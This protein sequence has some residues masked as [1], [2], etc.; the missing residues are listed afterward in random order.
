N[1][2]VTNLPAVGTL[3]NVRA[4]AGTAGVTENNLRGEARYLE[5]FNRADVAAMPALQAVLQDVTVKG[6][7]INHFKTNA[8]PDAA[9]LR[10]RLA[11]ANTAD[12][13]RAV[14]HDGG[15]FGNAG[16][17][18]NTATTLNDANQAARI[19]Q[20]R[21]EARYQKL[22]AENNA[23]L[24]TMQ[25]VKDHLSAPAVKQALI[26]HW[27]N[28]GN[29]A[30]DYA[31][32]IINLREHLRQL[33]PNDLAG[34]QSAFTQA[35]VF[36][37]VPN[38]DVAI[39][40]LIHT[41]AEAN[42]LRSQARS[43]KATTDASA[44]AV[45]RKEYF[46]HAIAFKKAL[47]KVKTNDRASLTKLADSI[48]TLQGTLKP[49]HELQ[50][51]LT[52]L[53]EALGSP[54]LNTQVNIPLAD[55]EAFRRTLSNAKKGYEGLKK[56]VEQI[57]EKGTKLDTEGLNAYL[58]MAKIY[59]DE[60]E[61]RIGS[62]SQRDEEEA[63]RILK[64]CK[65]MQDAIDMAEGQLLNKKSELSDPRGIIFNRSGK[66]KEVEDRLT[67]IAECRTTLNDTIQKIDQ[68]KNIG[69]V[70]QVNCFS[71]NNEVLPPGT[72]ET[73]ILQ[74][75]QAFTG[76]GAAPVAVMGVATVEKS[77][78]F[79]RGAVRINYTTLE[80]QNS[81]RPGDTSDFKVASVQGV[82]GNAY[83]SQLYYERAD[84]DKL[85]PDQLVKM[86]AIEVENFYAG[87]HDKNLKMTLKGN[88]HPKLAEAIT[89]Y[90]ELKKYS[91]PVTRIRLPE[92]SSS[93]KEEY[94]KEFA[95][96]LKEQAPAIFHGAEGLGQTNKTVEQLQEA[97]Q[98]TH[99]HIP[100]GPR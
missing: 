47:D 46:D 45:Y 97:T 37:A 9:T 4:A 62:I 100:R 11:G 64:A 80:K 53:F 67:I 86:A 28:P 42:N 96:H 20:L 35:N 22:M 92:R 39:Q 93:K 59:Q 89:V 10:T 43:S 68:A 31:N 1:A 34:A 51:P 6:A 99:T 49:D 63:E 14:F 76:G 69:Q 7:L 87:L 18:V 85:K 52:K 8:A 13:M 55:P 15:V 65:K 16:L 33:N 82:I 60:A 77:N 12:L 78:R 17:D 38:L 2:I 48:R 30:P 27:G 3:A 21:G 72:T 54:A 26:T 70:Q 91:T 56:S 23:T 73:D 88:M 94:K 58:E 83:Q 44:A 19:A 75:V 5:F 79:D 25:A 71:D 90:C 40:G 81:P 24:T 98:T 74:K 84:I 57:I 66:L 29:A 50:K 36:G 61:R 95:K 32:A 41:N